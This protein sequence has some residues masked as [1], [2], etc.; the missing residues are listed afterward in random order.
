MRLMLFLLTFYTALVIYSVV[1]VADDEDPIAIQVSDWSVAGID[2]VQDVAANPD[3]CAMYAD[4]DNGFRLEFK[5]TRER[6]TALRI[7]T[8]DKTN[9]VLNI[10]G[11]VGMGVGKNSYAL[12]SRHENGRIDASLLTVPNLA[13]KLKEATVFRMKLGVRN[14]YF[15]LQGFDEGYHRLMV[16]MGIREPKTIQVVNQESA[17]PRAPSTPPI[18]QK[19]SNE[20]EMPADPIDVVDA[21]ALESFQASDNLVEGVEGKEDSAQAVSDRDDSESATANERQWT[22]KKGQTLSEILKDWAGIAGVNTHFAMSS[23]PALSR[24]ITTNGSFEVAVNALLNEVGAGDS[25]TT[26]IVKNAEGRVTHIAGYQGGTLKGVEDNPS[27][28]TNR[29]RALQGTDLRKV[30]KRWSIKNNVDF[31]WQSPETFLLPK[32]MKA[33]VGYNQAVALLLS[34]FEGQPV[35]PVG[36]LNIDPDTGQKSLIVKTSRSSS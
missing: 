33:N 36:Q 17:V 8:T 20:I 1:A 3:H 29:W 12:Q 26:A 27:Q 2:G 21:V 14:Y 10:K 6:L 32:S 30:L 35:R 24:D 34:Q 9:T 7:L 22:A 16:C 23:N 11:F 28:G 15:A 4:Y 18:E 31:V 19:T 5:A 13:E 25:K